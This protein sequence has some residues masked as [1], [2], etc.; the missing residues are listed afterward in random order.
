MKEIEQRDEKDLTHIIIQ[1][2]TSPT[3][4]L[5]HANTTCEHGNQRL[6]IN[7]CTVVYFWPVFLNNL[8][9]FCPPSESS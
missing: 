4:V 3:K 6:R 5:P 7:I 2:L 1:K 9:I 8:H